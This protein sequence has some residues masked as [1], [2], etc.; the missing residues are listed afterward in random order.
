MVTV[1]VSVRVSVLIRR[2]LT[3][4]PFDSPRVTKLGVFLS[5]P[6]SLSLSLAMALS[7]ALLAS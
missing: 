6:L 4:R 1:R 3:L 7:L 2:F 5:L